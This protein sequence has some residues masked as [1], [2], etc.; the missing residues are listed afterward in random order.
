MISHNYG[1]GMPVY[2]L[3]H[4]HGHLHNIGND[5]GNSN[6]YGHAHHPA[7]GHSDGMQCLSVHNFFA[8]CTAVVPRAAL[9]GNFLCLHRILFVSCCMGPEEGGGSSP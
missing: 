4:K 2:Q 6:G 5:N 8:F 3:E 7:Q 1:H 9:L